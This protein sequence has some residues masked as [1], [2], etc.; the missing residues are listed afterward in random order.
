MVGLGTPEVNC[1]SAGLAEI[2]LQLLNFEDTYTFAL[3]ISLKVRKCKYRLKQGTHSA[4]VKLPVTDVST[5]SKKKPIPVM[6][7]LSTAHTLVCNQHPT[8]IFSSLY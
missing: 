4:N 5:K 7:Q 6:Q 1:I 3:Y 2:A 8:L